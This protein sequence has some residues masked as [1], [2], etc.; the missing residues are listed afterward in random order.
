MGG[1]HCRA[2]V[3]SQVRAETEAQGHSVGLQGI[4]G[5]QGDVR[6]SSIHASIEFETM[7]GILFRQLKEGP[8]EGSEVETLDIVVD[9]VGDIE[10]YL[11]TVGQYLGRPFAK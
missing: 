1:E 3:L 8:V 10:P 4:V 6:V 5:R 2:N 7:S 11:A 9:H